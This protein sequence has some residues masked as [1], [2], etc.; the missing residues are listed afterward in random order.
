MGYDPVQ[1]WFEYK[2][3]CEEKWTLD[4]R[5]L[6]PY[7]KIHT[8]FEYYKLWPL[9]IEVPY[10]SSLIK[11]QSTEQGIKELSSFGWY[12]SRKLDMKIMKTIESQLIDMLE[13][14]L[15]QE[16]TQ[17]LNG[18]DNQEL[19]ST[20]GK[21]IRE[22]IMKIIQYIPIKDIEIENSLEDTM[23]NKSQTP[24]DMQ[25]QIQYPD[26]FGSVE[27]M[28]FCVIIEENN[29]EAQNSLY[30][31]LTTTSGG[32][33]IIREYKRNK[34]NINFNYE[35]TFDDIVD[36]I[37]ALRYIKHL[38]STQDYKNKNKI[39]SIV[40]D[41]LDLHIGGVA[42]VLDNIVLDYMDMR[43]LIRCFIQQFV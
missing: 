24:M 8:I 35:T 5:H 42:K 33:N 43:F 1:F 25:F 18:N 23:I 7:K 22:L 19:C 37:A 17:E 40:Y 30:K 12:R 27:V 4:P 32:R 15:T 13:L 11:L 26:L 20:F 10:I 38:Q 29:D 28:E 14:E 9:F 6:V 39:K 21:E 36:D 41:Q 34:H 3:G 31:F 16:L 2:Y